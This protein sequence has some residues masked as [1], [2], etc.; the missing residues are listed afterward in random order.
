[1]KFAKQNTIPSKRC[2]E[3]KCKTCPDVEACDLIYKNSG[4][5]IE[6][7]TYKPFE[8]IQE[9]MKQKRKNAGGIKE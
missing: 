1:M 4:E 6:P 8:N 3:H 7:L 5:E 2:L 9:F